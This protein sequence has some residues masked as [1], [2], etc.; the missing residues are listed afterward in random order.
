MCSS[1]SPRVSVSR[2]I[3]YDS[4][5]GDKQSTHKAVEIS[6][7]R[8]CEMKP[9][10]P[11][12]SA[13]FAYHTAYYILPAS[14]TLFLFLNTTHSANINPEATKYMTPAQTCGYRYGR[15]L[16]GRRSS[17]PIASAKV[18]GRMMVAKARARVEGSSARPATS[19]QRGLIDFGMVG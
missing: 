19:T 3:L 6:L 9:C 14:S 5:S 1:D 18:V 16:S 15:A 17:R 11:I 10:K 7:I 12:R 13:R 4:T 8:I 2:R